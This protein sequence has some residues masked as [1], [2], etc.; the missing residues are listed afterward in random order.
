M[1]GEHRVAWKHLREAL[2][3]SVAIGAVPLTLDALVGV[4]QQQIDFGQ[5]GSAAELLGL[6]LH[7]PAMEIDVGQLAELALGRLRKVL[8]PEQLEAAMNRGKMLKLDAVV[9][10]LEAMPEPGDLTLP[11]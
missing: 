3:E 9:A 11:Q 10:E 8:P 4:V 6:A 5:Y 2:I 1:L 7:H